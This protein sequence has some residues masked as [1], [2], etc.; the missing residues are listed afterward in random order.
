MRE[1]GG[2][3]VKEEGGVGVEYIP[4]IGE[5]PGLLELGFI[6]FS[7]CL[8][9]QNHTRTT[10]F[11]IHNPSDIYWTSSLVGFGFELKARSS[12]TL[13]ALSMDVRFFRRRASASCA[14]VSDAD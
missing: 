5:L 10:S 13:I 9:L 14:A 6:R 4:G 2:V 7:F 11:S 12:A 1:R 3:G 8:R